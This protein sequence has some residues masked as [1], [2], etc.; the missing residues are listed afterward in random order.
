MPGSETPTM[1]KRMVLSRKV[2]TVQKGRPK[3]RRCTMSVPTPR[4]EETTPAVTTART[5]EPWSSSAA[6][7]ATKGETI[8]HRTARRGSL[9][10]R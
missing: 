8:V 10:R 3:A 4:H 2:V 6:K 7:S 1:R 9:S 5:P